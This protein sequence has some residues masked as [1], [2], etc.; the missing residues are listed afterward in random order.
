[1]VRQ[2]LRALRRLYQAPEDPEL[3]SPGLGA[4]WNVQRGASLHSQPAVRRASFR[5]G[6]PAE[7]ETGFAGLRL[8]LPP[9]PAFWE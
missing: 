8:V 5:I 9:G 1:M 6:A 7:A 2:P 3:A 4:G